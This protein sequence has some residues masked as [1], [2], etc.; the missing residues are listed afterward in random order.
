MKYSKCVF[1]TFFLFFLW[2]LDN[3]VTRIPL[4]DALIV[5]LGN[6]SKSTA[7]IAQLQSKDNLSIFSFNSK[8]ELIDFL[9][10]KI[11]ADDILLIKGS[12]LMQMEDIVSSLSQIK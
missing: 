2:R 5:V 1:Q 11:K 12:R 10:S 8:V 3:V 7:K 6:L 4:L 9:K